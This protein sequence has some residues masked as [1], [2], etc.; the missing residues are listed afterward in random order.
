MDQYLSAE[1][2]IKKLA[3]AKFMEEINPTVSKHNI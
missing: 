1:G 2:K 3:C